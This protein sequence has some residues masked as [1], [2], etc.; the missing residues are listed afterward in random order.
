MRFPAAS[1]AL[2]LA[3]IS[4]WAPPALAGPP[5]DPT[6]SGLIAHD[7]T[8]PDPAPNLAGE[9]QLSLADAIAMGL[10]NNLDV[11]LQRHAPLIA[12]E[13]HRIAWGA[14]D[15]E[16]FSEFGYTEAQDP[17]ANLILG[18]GGGPV[19]ETTVRRTDGFGGFQGL[20]PWLGASYRMELAGA[21]TT[22][23]V[24]IQSLS[25]ELTSSVSFALTVPMLRGLIW[26]EPW[27]LVKTSA[28]LEETTRED[29]RRSLMDVV[30]AIEDAYWAL[31]AA[32]DGVRVAEKSRETAQALLDQ[33]QT[34]YEVGV[35][36]K[37]EI[38]QAEAGVAGREFELIVAR[39]QYETQM[40]QLIDLVLGPNLTPDSRL[41]V[42]PTDR[43][44]VY[45]QYDVDEAQATRIAFENRPELQI[46]ARE[47][48]RL[49]INMKFARNRRLPRLDA[50][51]SYG[52]RGLAGEQNP[53]TD[54][55]RFAA[56]PVACALDPPA[57]IDLG[58]FH[59]SFDD[60]FT[61][62]ASRQFT[63]RAVLSVPIP[64][65]A[66]RHSVSRAQL[67]LRRARVQKRR[68]EQNIILEV[69]N[70]VRLLRSA[71]EGIEAAEREVLAAAEQ[72]RAERIRLEYG[73]ST[74]FDVL[75][76]EEDFVNAEARKIRALQTYRSSVTGLDRFQGTILRNRSISIADASR[77]R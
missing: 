34:Q 3:V 29:F 16:W 26:N 14:Y 28:V 23:N 68:V 11:E 48:E 49:E 77:L 75:L 4:A 58:G 44:E 37:V 13:D 42:E 46:A 63:A 71:L 57:P 51:L 72:L 53:D 27:T 1:L 35:V 15:P 31:I 41:H 18:A 20:V 74:P 8:G 66:G 65:T 54:P 50:V 45:T 47:I 17:T 22:T 2:C 24:T 56:D 7:P 36:S 38:A 76:R 30:Q 33:T 19:S 64:N 5:G 60:Y 25:P 62:D 12:H 59:N 10:E 70:A 61:G 39:N 55:C 9:L 40:D 21:R 69:R 67:E 32:E 73:E 52:N 43:P 6:V